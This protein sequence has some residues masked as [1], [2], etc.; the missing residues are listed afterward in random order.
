M[1]TYMYVYTCG[2]ETPN[3]HVRAL[4]DEVTHSPI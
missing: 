4:G 1:Y 2:L 3:A